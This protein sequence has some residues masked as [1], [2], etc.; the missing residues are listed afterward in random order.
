MPSDPSG[1]G[2]LAGP[3]FLLYL[4]GWRIAHALPERLAYAVAN[5]LGTAAARLWKR[6]RQVVQ[7]NLARV[8]GER[9]GSP[10]LEGLVTEA[11]RSYA[12]Y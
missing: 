9:P 7:R 11:F 12:R 8:T 3:V 2:P 1:E 10:R 6:K 5:G 4:L